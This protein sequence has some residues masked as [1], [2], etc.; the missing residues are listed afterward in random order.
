MKKTSVY[1][2]GQALTQ[3]N[4]FDITQGQLA[5]KFAIKG[6]VDT[7]SND[8]VRVETFDE[9]VLI[10]RDSYLAAKTPAGERFRWHQ[11]TTE[12]FREQDL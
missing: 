6:K 4:D 10:Q 7:D 3:G 8:I 12:K 2:N 9:G 11:R 1:H 5:F